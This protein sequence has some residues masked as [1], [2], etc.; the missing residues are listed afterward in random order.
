MMEITLSYEILC[1]I[2]GEDQKLIKPITKDGG[3]F[4]VRA[5]EL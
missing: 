2:G 5:L 4:Q 3:R 1:K